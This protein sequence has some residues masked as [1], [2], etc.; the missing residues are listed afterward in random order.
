MSERSGNPSL[1]EP[2]SEMCQLKT[3]E[4]PRWLS[5]RIALSCAHVSIFIRIIFVDKR[6]RGNQV[7]AVHDVNYYLGTVRNVS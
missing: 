7:I 6:T 2:C 1:A 3:V 4:L 5:Y